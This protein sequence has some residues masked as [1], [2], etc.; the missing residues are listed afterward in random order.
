MDKRGRRIAAA[1]GAV[2]DKSVVENTM[3][4]TIQNLGLLNNPGMV[5]TDRFLL[6]LMEKAQTG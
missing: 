3:K 5:E 2:L 4:D 6:K 1:L